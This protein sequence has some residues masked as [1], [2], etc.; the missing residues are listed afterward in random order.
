MKMQKAKNRQDILYEGEHIKQEYW[1]DLWSYSNKKNMV[2]AQKYTNRPMRHI[3]ESWNRPM[4]I[5]P[6]D[7]CNVSTVK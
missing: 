4:L 7:L 1:Q 5:G 6:F 2:F 3:W